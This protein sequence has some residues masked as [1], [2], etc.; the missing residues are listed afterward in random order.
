MLGRRDQR[1]LPPGRR[2]APSVS[3]CGWSPCGACGA[4]LPAT[5]FAVLSPAGVAVTGSRGEQ[6]P[7]CLS[8]PRSP[9]RVAGSALTSSGPWR[10]R[11]E[12]LAGDPGRVS[13]ALGLAWG[14]RSSR[15]RCLLGREAPR[16]R[17]CCGPPRGHGPRMLSSDRVRFCVRVSCQVTESGRAVPAAEAWVSALRGHSCRRG[18]NRRVLCSHVGGWGVG[19]S[20]ASWP[21]R[22]FLL[23]VS[24]PSRILCRNAGSLPPRLLVPGQS[25]SPRRTCCA[26]SRGVRTSPASVWPRG[27]LSPEEGGS[28]VTPITGPSR[29]CVH[30]RSFLPRTA[31]PPAPPRVLLPLECRPVAHRVAPL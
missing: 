13:P 24:A 11:T 9:R 25:E 29:H 28:L 31:R 22:P 1:L 5:A 17:L 18:S 21:V 20:A 6:P 12:S 8:A 14:L 2:V 15:T 30:L 26:P 19:E 4:G 27:D 16:A 3:T 23:L 7:S 10:R